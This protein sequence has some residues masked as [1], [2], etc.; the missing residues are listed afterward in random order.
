MCAM[1]LS[2]DDAFYDDG[3]DYIGEVDASDDEADG[4]YEPHCWTCRGTGEGMYDGSRCF[5]CGGKG[6]VIEDRRY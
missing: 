5:S 1:C 3:D 4:D 6:Y 2:N